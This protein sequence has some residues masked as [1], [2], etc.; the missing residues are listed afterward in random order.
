MPESATQG[1]PSA[2]PPPSSLRRG[3]RR[4]VRGS[5][6]PTI[7]K[8]A[9]AVAG[10]ES[11]VGRASGGLASDMCQVR[12]IDARTVA[13]VRGEMP[14]ASTV[15]LASQRLRVLGDPT[16]LRLLAALARAEELCVCDLALLVGATVSE[17][18]VS[19]ALRLLRG[20]GLVTYRRSGKLAMY[21]L[22]D[23]SVRRLVD[24]L[25]AVST[26]SPGVVP[27]HDTAGETMRREA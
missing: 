2:V 11:P 10:S 22:T 24:D 21:R 3:A 7:A 19:H 15:A 14:D 12:C 13:R 4:S 26:V 6:P 9:S 23:A 17:S 25:F 27:S 5:S 18:A 8:S 1:D 16:R 20:D